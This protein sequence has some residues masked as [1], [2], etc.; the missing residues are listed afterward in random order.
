M[1]RIIN[2]GIQIAHSL[3]R[4]F[5]EIEETGPV[6]FF[7]AAY[8][9]ERVPIRIRFQELFVVSLFTSV[10]AVAASYVPASRAA[11]LKPIDI[12]RRY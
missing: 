4:Q 6:V 2:L 12:L 11:L 1:E 8:Y 9:L 7:D 10:L 3:F 5:M